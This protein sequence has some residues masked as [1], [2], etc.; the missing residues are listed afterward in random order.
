MIININNINYK[1]NI[2]IDR[3]VNVGLKFIKSI[4]IFNVATISLKQ[5]QNHKNQVAFHPWVEA[6]YKE[7]T[8]AAIKL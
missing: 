7:I 6:L 5:S 3:T 8:K 4:S 2:G 1:I